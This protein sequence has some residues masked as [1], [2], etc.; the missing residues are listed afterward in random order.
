MATPTL[1]T[2]AEA[3]ERLR[4]HRSGVYERI[5]DGLIKAVNLAKPGHRP[6]LLVTE[7]EITAYLGRCEMEI[8]VVVPRRK[9]R[10]RT[11]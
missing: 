7:A 10:R 11:T 5:A 9:P 8:P 4:L 1:L 3:A 2:V 6:H